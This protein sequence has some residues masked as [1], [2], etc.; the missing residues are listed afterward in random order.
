MEDSAIKELILSGQQLEADARLPLIYY[1]VVKS[2]LEP[3]HRN[4]SMKLQ[5]IQ[6]ILKKDLKVICS[7][8]TFDG[9]AVS[10]QIQVV[11]LKSRGG[12]PALSVLLLELNPLGGA[13]E[14]QNCQIQFCFIP[15][16]YL[17]YRT[18]LSLKG[19][20]PK[21]RDLLFLQM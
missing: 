19:E 5:D 9:Y 17:F 3:K 4:R 21:H 8:L 13:A 12:D 18:W 1:D 6:Y 20:Y 16:F 7:I 10:F 15:I 2:G 14:A 11:L